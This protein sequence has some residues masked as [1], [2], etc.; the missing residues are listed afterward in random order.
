MPTFDFTRLGR[1]GFGTTALGGAYRATSESDAQ[2]ALDEAAACGITYFDTAPMYGH[3]LAEHRLGRFLRESGTKAVVSTKVGR[4]LSPNR[5]G[6]E[7]TMF[8][9]ILPFDLRYDYGYDGVMRSIEDS[10]QRLGRAS[11]DIAFVHDVSPRWHGE[12]LHKRFREVINGGYK[13]LERLKSDGTIGAIGVG[14]NDPDVLVAFGKA[15]P[16][17][18]FMI[19]GSYTLINQSAAEQLFPLCL[20]RNI[21]IAVAAPFAAGLLATARETRATMNLPVEAIRKADALET[22]CDRYNVPLAA[23]ALQFS[24]MH[25]AVS[26]V[27]TGLRTAAEVRSAQEFLSFPIPDALWAEMRAEG[28]I[29]QPSTQ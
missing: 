23:A 27:V 18:I 7:S 19:S 21:A 16:F 2:A 24:G 13:A 12:E 11:V 14:V 26:A 3:G 9:G 29:T 5:S 10:L 22:V 20:E 4:L 28:L 15:A 8:H 6:P 17:D 25:R 1:L